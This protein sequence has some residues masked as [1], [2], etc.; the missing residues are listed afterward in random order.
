MYEWFSI[1]IIFFVS[2]AFSQHFSF[3]HLDQ[4]EYSVCIKNY[5]NGE[6]MS[7]YDS[8][9][10][11]LD[12]ED[13]LSDA[14][15]RQARKLTS[16]QQRLLREFQIN[17]EVENVIDEL[18]LDEKY[19]QTNGIPWEG[20]KDAL[21]NAL[22]SC[23]DVVPPTIDGESREV[24]DVIDYILVDWHDSLY[25][26]AQTQEG[27]S[28]LRSYA[29][30]ARSRLA[31]AFSS[32]SREEFRHLVRALWWWR[33]QRYFDSRDRIYPYI[34]HIFFRG[35]IRCTETYNH[36]IDALRNI[37]SHPMRS[38]DPND[39]IT[40]ARE[41]ELDRLLYI[42]D[43][44]FYSHS[45]RNDQIFNSYASNFITSAE[46]YFE[47]HNDQFYRIIF[48]NLEL[49]ARGIRFDAD[50]T[51]ES[52]S[53]VPQ[54]IR[55]ILYDD[56]SYR[57]YLRRLRQMYVDSREYSSR[58][59]DPIEENLIYFVES[60]IN[61]NPT[62][63]INTF[64]GIVTTTSTTTTISPAVS[65]TNKSQYERKRGKNREKYCNSKNYAKRTKTTRPESYRFQ[66]ESDFTNKKKS[67]ESCIKQQFVNNVTK[68][69]DI[70]VMLSIHK[71]KQTKT[72]RDVLTLSS[73]HQFAIEESIYFI[74]T[75]QFIV[76]NY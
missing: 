17:N 36:R 49:Q 15:Q 75:I 45:N 6:T 65:T 12:F 13:F 20:L 19:S 1:A 33:A 69:N 44:S 3:T 40:L 7:D 72:Y 66:K 26:M 54:E 67:K 55:A 42:H 52:L 22:K 53:R 39:R 25:D 68:S 46:Y 47:R 61:E 14:A 50:D 23:S 41:E 64:F 48:F 21:Q 11:D 73:S 60:M 30:N 18:K 74:K 32:H 37:L 29:S 28:I 16:T 70:S 59:S 58:R 35:Q 38:G 76:S 34:P 43:V 31:R 2:S 63:Y 8:E 51:E 9:E 62:R 71:H 5:I 57:N 56:D 10:I 24:A 4:N 27:R